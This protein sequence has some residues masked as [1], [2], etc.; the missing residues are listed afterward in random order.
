MG[1]VGETDPKWQKT[2]YLHV[3]EG[4]PGLIQMGQEPGYKLVEKEIK[5]LRENISA[6][7]RASGGSWAKVT[8]NHRNSV[9][10]AA[11]QDVAA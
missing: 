8:K 11:K 9:R 7:H 2:A 3:P 5:N 6:G 1:L 10:K 4:V